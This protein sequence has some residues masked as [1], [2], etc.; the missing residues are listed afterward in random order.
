MGNR[1]LWGEI[2]EKYLDK[3]NPEIPVYQYSG[4]FMYP[5]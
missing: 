2:Q 1:R 5:C 3:G 4:S